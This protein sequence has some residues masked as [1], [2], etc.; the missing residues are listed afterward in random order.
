MKETIKLNKRLSNETDGGNYKSR[1]KRWR[2]TCFRKKTHLTEQKTYRFII[3]EED[4]CIS[5][6][7][8]NKLKITSSSRLVAE[9]LTDG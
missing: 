1:V 3:P 7:N 6:G 8:P 9:L 4:L 5:E 2:L